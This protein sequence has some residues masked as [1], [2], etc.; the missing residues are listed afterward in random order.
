LRRLSSERC[1]CKE[2]PSLLDLPLVLNGLVAAMGVYFWAD[3]VWH[4]I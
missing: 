1:H 3:V 2:R 4:V